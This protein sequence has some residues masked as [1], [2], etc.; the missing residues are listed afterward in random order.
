MLSPRARKFGLYPRSSAAFSTRARVAP[1]TD[2]P[3]V[4]VR[5]TADRDTPA[6][7]ATCVSV[8]AILPCPV[9]R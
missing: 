7:R 9:S 8:I 3:G 4:K 6:R 2:A 5:D 1:D